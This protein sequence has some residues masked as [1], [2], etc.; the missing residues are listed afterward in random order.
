[1][2]ISHY[3]TTES[4]YKHG[5]ENRRKRRSDEEPAIWCREVSIALLLALLAQTFVSSLTALPHLDIPTPQM[6]TP[7]AYDLY[8]RAADSCKSARVGNKNLRLELNANDWY[9]GRYPQMYSDAEA[10]ALAKAN[11]PVLTQIHQG[12]TCE[13][14]Q[15]PIRSDRFEGRGHAD[16]LG[17]LGRLLLVEAQVKLS[18]GDHEGAMRSVLDTIQFGND[19]MKGGTHSVIWTCRDIRR[20]AL[21]EAV[22]IMPSLTA[23]GARKSAQHLEDLLEKQPTFASV[24]Q[25]EKWSKQAILLEVLRRFDGP[26][27]YSYVNRD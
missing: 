3:P 26:V 13:C 10:A 15:P 16:D 11:A 22:K 19:L 2:S 21:A 24:L 1:M 7:N 4:R 20:N 8:L 9:S 5:S 27:E 6:P 18:R 25:E 17:H 23:A 12:L 14:M